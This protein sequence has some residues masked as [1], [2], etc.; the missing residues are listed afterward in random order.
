MSKTFT[1]KNIAATIDNLNMSGTFDETSTTLDTAIPPASI[2]LFQLIDKIILDLVSI[3]SEVKTQ[4]KNMLAAL[5]NDDF[6]NAYTSS[7][8]TITLADKEAATSGTAGRNDLTITSSTGF[9]KPAILIRSTAGD[10]SEDALF[11]FLQTI[12]HSI[13]K[14]NKNLSDA[15]GESSIADAAYSNDAS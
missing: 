10:L 1:L 4:E 9:N 6:A 8:S 7:I 11:Q 15:A 5:A 2:G 14:I 12:S 13:M 3:K